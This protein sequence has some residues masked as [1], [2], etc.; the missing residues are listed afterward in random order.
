MHR[1][2]YRERTQLLCPE[3]TTIPKSLHIH[4]GSSLNI[5][6]LRPLYIGMCVCLIAQSCLTLCN[7]M[8]R[9]LPGFSVH[10]ILQARILEWVAIPFFRGSSQ[11]SHPGLPHC[12]WILYHLSY[13]GT[14]NSRNRRRT[15]EP[16]DEGDRGE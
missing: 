1:A 15:K 14:P 16:L 3:S 2:R 6:I 12:R 10:G 11:G 9:I 7:P 5:I 8:D 4:Q 13:Q